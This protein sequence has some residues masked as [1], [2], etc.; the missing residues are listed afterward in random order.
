MPQTSTFVPA[1]Q[2]SRGVTKFVQD[3]L[4]DAQISV[5]SRPKRN[6]GQILAMNP[7]LRV[8]GREKL[9]LLNILEIRYIRGRAKRQD[10]LA[11]PPLRLRSWTYTTNSDCELGLQRTL[12]LESLNARPYGRRSRPTLLQ[13]T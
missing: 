1:S 6:L 8:A 2:T 5:L 11:I 10:C 7:L 9:T 13:P 4:C 12:Q 3:C